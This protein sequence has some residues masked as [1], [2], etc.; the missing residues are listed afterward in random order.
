MHVDQQLVYVNEEG[1]HERTGEK[2]DCGCFKGEMGQADA[3]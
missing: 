1:N 3:G 2:G